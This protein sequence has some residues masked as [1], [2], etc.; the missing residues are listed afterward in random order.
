MK[1]VFF[2]I[3]SLFM[4]T[5]AGVAQD[6]DA[7]YATNMLKVGTKAPAL[8][9]PT[10]EGAEIALSHFKGSYVVLEFW[11]SWCPDCRQITPQV[12]SL[13]AKYPHENV[14]FL[15]VSFDTDKQSWVDYTR[16]KTP[17]LNVYHVSNL[18]KMKQSA[19]AKA[20]KVDWIP[21]FY[22]INPEGEIVLATVMVEKVGQKLEEL[23]Q[24]SR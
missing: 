21:M 20:F 5:L 16:R 9:L 19:V 8:A 22:I 6:A 3:L 1:K 15:Q 17:Q 11:A 14:A 24:L 13:I 4:V 10:P 23:L 18:E 12:D 2:L 7:K